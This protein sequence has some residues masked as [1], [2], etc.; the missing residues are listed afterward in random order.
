MPGM[1]VLQFAFGGT[2]DNPH[3]PHMHERDCVVYTGTHDN[4]TTL[5]WYSSLDGETLRR[6]DF[7]LRVTPGSMPDPLIRATLGSVGLLA[8]IPVQDI[9]KLGSEG[10]MNTPGTAVGNWSWMLPAGSL[11]GELAHECLQLNRI[12][13]RV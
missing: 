8:V 13:G 10:R 5:G 2:G 11:T 9:L 6:V 7:F 4:D 12:F 3:L 1:R